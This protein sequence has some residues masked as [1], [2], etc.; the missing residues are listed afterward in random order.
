MLAPPGEGFFVTVAWFW[1]ISFLYFLALTTK[2]RQLLKGKTK[3][4]QV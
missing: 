2:G 4:P 1:I 3:P